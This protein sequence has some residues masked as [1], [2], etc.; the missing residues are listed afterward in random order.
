MTQ[1]A[2]HDLP[3]DIDWNLI[4]KSQGVIP[5]FM[6]PSDIAEAVLFLASSAASSITAANL[7][8]DRGVIW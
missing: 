3:A 1:K 6:P 8:V 4:A 2:A 7:V 5:G